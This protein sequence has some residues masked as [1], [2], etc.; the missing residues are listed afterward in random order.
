MIASRATRANKKTSIRVAKLEKENDQLT[1]TITREQEKYKN[2]R[3][4]YEKAREAQQSL[5]E[6]EKEYKKIVRMFNQ[7]S[8][9]VEALKEKVSEKK[10]SSN[11]LSREVLSHLN[12][13]CPSEDQMKLMKEESSKEV[14]KRIKKRMKK[15]SDSED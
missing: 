5:K 7:F 3:I 2:L 11:V 10:Y 14:F 4:E 9:G 1:Q 13:H 12:E 6:F 15:E 8:A